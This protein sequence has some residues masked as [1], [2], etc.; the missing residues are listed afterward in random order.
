MT[1][2]RGIEAAKDVSHEREMRNTYIEML[3]SGNSLSLQHVDEEDPHFSA[4]EE[5]GFR[6]HKTLLLEHVPDRELLAG[7]VD[8]SIASM[9]KLDE[10]GGRGI[11]GRVA[12]EEG[13]VGREAESRHQCH[14]T[15]QVEADELLHIASGRG[16]G[17]P[18]AGAGETRAA[19]A[20]LLLELGGDDGVPLAALVDALREEEVEGAVAGRRPQHVRRVLLLAI[21]ARGR[22]Y[23]G[24]KA[25]ETLLADE[26]EQVKHQ[27]AHDL[28]LVRRAPHTYLAKLTLKRQLPIQGSL[29]KRMISSA[30]GPESHRLRDK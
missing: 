7:E 20:L 3:L 9:A 26:A 17:R 16:T 8:G 30:A 10:D 6:E 13:A 27:S 22:G 28:L 14:V 11:H 21:A 4:Q 1:R 2:R 12:L 5:S 15:E 23:R 25:A 24:E 19:P 18:V 29:Q